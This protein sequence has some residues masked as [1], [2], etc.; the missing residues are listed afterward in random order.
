M[1]VI[2]QNNAEDV[3]SFASSNVVQIVAGNSNSL[4]K[5]GKV[6]LSMHISLWEIDFQVNFSNKIIIKRNNKNINKKNNNNNNNN[7]Y[8]FL[9]HNTIYVFQ[10]FKI[11]ITL[12]YLII[13]I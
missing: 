8:K 2:I 13:K 6:C 9:R 1:E 5:N 11:N 12:H 7:N 4:Q 3:T 10:R